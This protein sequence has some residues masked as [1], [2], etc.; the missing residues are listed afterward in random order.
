MSSWEI[1]ANA[2]NAG[3]I[4]LAA[5]NNVHTW[6]I[7]ILG[8]ALFGY[9]FLEAR[10][11]ADLTLQVF[12]IVTSVIG[13]VNW[14]KG[15]AGSDLPV[16]R[17]KPLG[18]VLCTLGAISAAA[19][20]GLLLLRFTNAASPVWDSLVLMFS[21]LGQFLLMGR[22]VENWWAWII[23]NT[24]A[25]PLYASRGLTLTAVLYALFWINAWWGLRSWH[26]QLAR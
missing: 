25:V 2:A 12:F 22:R 7:G 5:R 20:Y 9:V 6:W 21:V 14:Q 3:S 11:Y 18:L 19:G 1:A 26:K 13:W 8:C 15:Q 4:F 10:L 17:T 24:I 23:V 16:R